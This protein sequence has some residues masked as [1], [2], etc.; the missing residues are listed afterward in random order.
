MLPACCFK[1][2]CEPKIVV[3]RWE[4]TEMETGKLATESLGRKGERAQQVAKW[5]SYT[6][7]D[8]YPLASRRWLRGKFQTW[9]IGL[10]ASKEANKS[11]SPLFE[12]QWLHQQKVAIQWFGEADFSLSLSLALARLFSNYLASRGQDA[13]VASQHLQRLRL[14]FRPAKHNLLALAAHGAALKLP[15]RDLK[16]VWTAYRWFDARLRNATAFSA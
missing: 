4:A 11:G 14:W 6:Y 16:A 3:S 12:R 15:D 10:V 9:L 8:S 1:V 7:T 5:L 2:N 13:S